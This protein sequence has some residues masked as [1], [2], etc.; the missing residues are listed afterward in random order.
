MSST[1][2]RRQLLKLLGMSVLGTSFS[3]CVTSPARATT[4]NWGY[5]GKVGPEHWGELSPDFALCQ[6][7]RKQTPIDLQIA[8]VKDVHSSSQDLLVVNY[9]PTALH[10]INNGKTVQVNYPPG[11]YLKYAHQKFE[12]LQFHFHH[13]SEHR[14]DGKLYDMELHLV[15]RSKSGDLAVMGIFLQAGAFNPTLQIIWDAIPQKQGTEKQIADINIDVSQFLPAQ[16]RFFTYSGSL[17]TPPCS[18]N[19]LWCVMATPIEA[20]PAQIAQF[21]QTFPQNARPVQPLN[22]RLV[23]EAI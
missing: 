4:V 9:Q 15:H 20:S 22:D 1:L 21:S 13:F 6:I 10:L 11:S 23:I 17:T 14:V 3:S 8:D 18:E 5:I 2:H 19:V 7:G 16:R 12:L